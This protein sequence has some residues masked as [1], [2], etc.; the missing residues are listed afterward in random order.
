VAWSIISR[1]AA[2]LL[3]LAGLAATA[4]G[5][6]YGWTLPLLWCAIGPFVP[7]DDSMV[8]RVVAWMLQPPDSPA[9]TWTAVILATTG[10]ATYTFR[11]GRR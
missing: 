2:G 1:D 4:G 7:H 10:A 11:G 8:S 3:G 5:G 9:A 6:Q